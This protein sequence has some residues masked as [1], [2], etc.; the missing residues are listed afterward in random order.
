MRRA[1]LLSDDRAEDSLGWM[2]EHGEGVI[3]LHA[4]RAS[5][6]RTARAVQLFVELD[7]ELREKTGGEHDLDDLV[8][9][10]MSADVVSEARLRS[11]AEEMLGGTSKALTV[12]VL[13]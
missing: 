2:R 3:T 7:A 10:L 6:E 9:A 12:K 11:E 5:G 8:R 13:D 4:D 1:G